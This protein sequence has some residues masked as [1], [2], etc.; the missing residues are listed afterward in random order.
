MGVTRCVCREVPFGVVVRAAEELRRAGCEIS[1][2]MIVEA[3][4]AGTGCGTCRPYLA[5]AIATGETNLPVMS[6]A[7]CRAWLEGTAVTD[8]EPRPAQPVRG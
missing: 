5:R 2:D 8:R 1:I 6:Q 4:T 3:T 7:E